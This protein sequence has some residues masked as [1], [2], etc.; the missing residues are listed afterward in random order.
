MTEPPAS[1][2]DERR[3][4]LSPDTIRPHDHRFFY[5]NAGTPLTNKLDFCAANMKEK[6]VSV[7]LLRLLFVINSHHVTKLLM[8]NI[9]IRQYSEK[10]L[11]LYTSHLQE[12]TIFQQ[13]VV[14]NQ[15]II[16]FAFKMYFLLDF[17][18]LDAQLPKLPS[19]K[20][21]CFDF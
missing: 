18:S 12:I 14:L 13:Q 17:S 21:L 2:G 4:H 1:W 11:N 9:S 7:A 8:H 5:C 19:F 10:C 3:L 16:I 6:T 15:P 20:A